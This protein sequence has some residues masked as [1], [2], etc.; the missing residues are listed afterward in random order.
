M[1]DSKTKSKIVSAIIIGIIGSM[2]VSLFSSIQQQS[3]A[4]TAA[5]IEQKYLQD[6]RDALQSNNT[7]GAIRN[8]LAIL[9]WQFNEVYPKIESFLGNVSVTAS[10]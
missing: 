2:V 1:N 9:E 7:T 10:G 5:E 8:I 3:F 4:A 6:A